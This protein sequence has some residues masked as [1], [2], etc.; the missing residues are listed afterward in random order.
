MEAAKELRLTR[1]ADAHTRDMA[2]RFY[3][4][5]DSFNGRPWYSRIGLWTVAAGIMYLFIYLRYR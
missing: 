1:A 2:Q 5:H 3:Y 4:A